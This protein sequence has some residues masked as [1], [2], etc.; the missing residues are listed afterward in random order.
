LGFRM[1]ACT[2]FAHFVDGIRAL[3]VK[4]VG[5]EPRSHFPLHMLPAEKFSV[6]GAVHEKWYIGDGRAWYM[7]YDKCTTSR[8]GI[9][10][11]H[12]K[13]KGESGK[14][15]R[16]PGGRR[17]NPS[18]L[19]FIQ[20]GAQLQQNPQAASTS[21]RILDGDDQGGRPS[22]IPPPPS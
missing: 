22:S 7:Y 4:S 3:L 19:G 20:T 10:N 1:T 17:P 5:H 13:T 12:L 6:S 15:G 18:P 21:R 9:S 8:P 14:T 11:T 2:T 16:A